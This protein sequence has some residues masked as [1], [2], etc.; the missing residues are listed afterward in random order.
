MDEGSA[1]YLELLSYAGPWSL[2]R[3][4]EGSAL[5]LELLSHADT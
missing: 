5:Y 2:P 3:I 4:D 1:L